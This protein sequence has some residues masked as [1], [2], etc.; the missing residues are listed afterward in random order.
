MNTVLLGCAAVMALSLLLSLL[1]LCRG[2]EPVDRLMATQLVATL[3]ITQLLVLAEVSGDASLR[4]V[5]LVLALLG[6]VSVA[7][8]LRA[9]P[10][11][12]RQV[13]R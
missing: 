1:R 13:S 5:A 11:D 3:A 10:L 9:A 8:L 6:A 7:T 2:S 4:L 12:A